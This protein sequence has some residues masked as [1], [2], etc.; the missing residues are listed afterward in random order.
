VSLRPWRSRGRRTLLTR[1]PWMVVG[2]EAFE[3]P[4]GR[5]VDDFVWAQATDWVA[6]VAVTTERRIVLERCYKPGN[7]RIGLVVPAGGLGEGE[8]PLAAAQRELL[9]ET[10]YFAERWTAL[11]A[12]R[13]DPN[14]GLS[15]GHLFLAEGARKVREPASGDLEEIEIVL[16]GMDE[17]LAAVRAGHVPGLGSAGCL[18]LAA[19]ELA[20]R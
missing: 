16:A 12:Y 9:E 15:T 6:I 20:R 17:A 1:A 14:C 18:A 19:A 4:D 11:G 10:G 2:E 13:L 7:G 8:E 5:T 3:L